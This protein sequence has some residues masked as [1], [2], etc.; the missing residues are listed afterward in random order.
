MRKRIMPLRLWHTA[1][2]YGHS[3]G[4]DEFV[5][6]IPYRHSQATDIGPPGFKT[7][8][9]ALLRNNAQFLTE[10]SQGSLRRHNARRVYQGSQQRLTLGRRAK[11]QPHLA[12]GGLAQW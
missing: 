2:R 12:Q 6:P 7:Y 4:R 1:A 3:Q 9:K 11:R 8:G 5:P 10:A